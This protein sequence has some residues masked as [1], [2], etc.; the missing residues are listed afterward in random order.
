MRCSISNLFRRL[1]APQARRLSPP[2]LLVATTLALAGCEPP[3]AARE[4]ES[5]APARQPAGVDLNVLLISIDTTRADHLA[6]YGH[7][8][9]KTSN[10]DRLATEGTRFTQCIAP[11]PITLPSHTSM[12]TGTYPFV[13][14]V[15]DNGQFHVHADNLMLAEVLRD[16][17]YTTAAQI[18]AY[19]LNREFGLDQGFDTYDDVAA[20]RRP[21]ATADARAVTE[22]RAEEICAG[23][24]TWL[25]E[26]TD[27]KFFLFVHF[28]DPH[29][30]Y[31]PPPR[32]AARYKNP[33]LGEI[34]YVDE[35]IGRLLNVLDELDLTRRTVLILTSD[36]GEGLGEHDEETHA[37]FVYDTTIAVPLIFRCPGRVPAGRRV[38][39]QVRLIDLAP[40]VLDL[41]GMPPLP[42]AQGTSLWPLISGRSADLNLAAYSETFYPRL[43]MGYSWYRAWRRDGWKYIHAKVPELYHVS[44]DPREEHNLAAAEPERV[45]Q[46]RAELRRLLAEARPVAGSVRQ[47]LTREER[48]AL[49]SLGYVSGGAASTQFESELDLFE[50][51]GPD[52][53]NYTG[54]SRLMAEAV[55]LMF[56]GDYAR[57]ER[58]LRSLLDRAGREEASWYVH[59]TLATV[60]R[61][62]NKLDEAVEHYRLALEIRPD[63]GETRSSLG[64]VLA[65][66]GRL[67][68]AIEAYEQA[69]QCPPVFANTHYEYGLV[70]AGKG[71]PYEALRHQQAAIQLDPQFARAHAEI[72]KLSAR[73][74]RVQ[75]AAE[76]YGR[77][78]EIRPTDPQIRGSYAEFLLAQRRP[79]EALDQFQHLVQLVPNSARA[80]G[81][82][83]MVYNV[84]GKPDEAIASLRKAVALNPRLPQAWQGLGQV[85]SEQR[86]Y[87]EALA[88]F[89][90]GQE[91]AP[92]RVALTNSLAWLLAT[93]PDDELRDGAEALRLAHGLEQAGGGRDPRVLDTLAAALAEQGRFSEAVG[94][95]DRAIRLANAAGNNAL[96]IELKQRRGLYEANTPFCLPPA[97]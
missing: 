8:K 56:A 43:N 91:A 78:I 13:H 59:K 53:K 30:S 97:P 64:H 36:H 18:A 39:A 24:E 44:E 51:T 16:A 71:R 85:L 80:H 54:Q 94:V 17:G 46:M 96:A 47:S 14:G 58:V 34:A 74:G 4:A 82:L 45:A 42:D 62:Q 84:L 89:R 28:F 33:Y 50:P 52:P 65:T 70:L 79:A 86:R 2:L 27:K 19:V 87:A 93:C 3:G 12:M 49:E 7:P 32:F 21:T 29:R 63:D 83:G 23:A 55:D 88:A 48:R 25:R 11:V 10:I 72:G 57:A 60:L 69:L 37:H 77:A 90:S 38:E 26:N 9:I 92:R 66:A 41:L 15:R 40:T 67:D 5:A 6:C 95:I 75:E 73:M 35:Q 31:A 1:V 76:A 22:R 20:A 61:Y 68:D 81:G